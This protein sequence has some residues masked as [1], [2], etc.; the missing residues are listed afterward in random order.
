MNFRP[1]AMVAVGALALAA[2]GCKSSP[3]APPSCMAEVPQEPAP[4]APPAPAARYTPTVARSVP[5]APAPALPKADPEMQAKID[6]LRTSVEAQHRQNAEIEAK[7]REIEAGRTA[8]APVVAA[9]TGAGGGEQAARRL[10][11][12]LKGVPGA[13]VLVEGSTAVVVITDSFDSG[14]DRLK[15]NPDVRSG[16]RAVAMAVARHPEARVT[17]TGHTDSVPIQRSKWADNNALSQARAEMVAKTLAAGGAPRE[18][19]T[20]KGVGSADPMVS[21]EKTAADRAKNRRVE[22]Q[23]AFTK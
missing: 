8:P 16:L 22:V 19:L 21:P 5:V 1:F 15:N 6:V 7:I 2:T 17:I 13:S 12:E 9:S 14:V 3:C 4:C 11:D 20:V 23:F 18:R 10:A